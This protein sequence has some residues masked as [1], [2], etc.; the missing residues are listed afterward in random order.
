MTPAAKKTAKTAAP[1]KMP[2]SDVAVKA[3]TGKTWAQWCT[4]LDRAKAGNMSHRE[5]ADLLDSKFGVGP[6]WTQMV[7]VG[8][9]RARGRRAVNQTTRGFSASV[10]RTIGASAAAAFR[11]WSDDVA[12]AAWLP[13]QLFTVRASTA[14]KSL[15]ITWPDGTNVDVTL[16]SRGPKKCVVAVQHDK[17]VSAAAVRG[18]KSYWGLRLDALRDELE[19]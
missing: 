1:A 15:R 18:A 6:W 13:G 17:L 4:V 19:R 10:T 3:K 8:Y 5:I 12:R 2:V 14:G 9:E 7:T 11:S 16:T